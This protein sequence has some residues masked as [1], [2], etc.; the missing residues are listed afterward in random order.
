MLLILKV[1]S[2][3]S[4]YFSIVWA[5]SFKTSALRAI[6]LK[7]T[8]HSSSKLSCLFEMLCR[9]ISEPRLKKA[10]L[11]TSSVQPFSQ[12]SEGINFRLDTLTFTPSTRGLVAQY[13]KNLLHEYLR[14]EA[15]LKL[16]TCFMSSATLFFARWSEGDANEYHKEFIQTYH[17]IHTL[18]I[19]T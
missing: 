7:A 11:S 15:C 17:L 6:V 1:K 14:E 2:W 3:E 19:S 10:Y 8:P 13:A 5:L 12:P 16:K 4:T 18:S 9:K